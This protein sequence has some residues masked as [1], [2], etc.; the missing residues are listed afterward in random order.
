[1]ITVSLVTIHSYRIFFLVMRTFKFFKIYLL[2]NFQ[3]RNTILIL[4]T[5]LYIPFSWLVLYWKFVPFDPLHPFCPP[6]LLKSPVCFLYLGWLVGWLFLHSTYKWSHVV[7]VF[8]NL[9]LCNIIPLRSIHIVA[10]GKISYFFLWLTHILECV[11]IHIYIF[12]FFP[13]KL[14]S[15]IFLFTIFEYSWQ[16]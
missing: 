8:I 13:S 16:C 9:L 11:C 14:W 4:A 10:D 12:S 1:M 2:G 5:M 6:Y 3:I 7:F 15:F